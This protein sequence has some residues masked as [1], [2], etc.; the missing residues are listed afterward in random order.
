ML[1]IGSYVRLLIQRGPVVTVR[2]VGVVRHRRC[3]EALAVPSL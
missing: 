2:V 3:K 1:G